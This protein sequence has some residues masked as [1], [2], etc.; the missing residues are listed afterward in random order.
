MC[1]QTK[2]EG[3]DMVMVHHPEALGDNYE[4]I[5]E[6]LGVRLAR[7]VPVVQRTHSRTPAR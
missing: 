4:E 2:S 5:V 6:S 1:A 3:V 7:V